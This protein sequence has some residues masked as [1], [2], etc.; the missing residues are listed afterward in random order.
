MSATKFL[1]V[2]TQRQCCKAFTGLSI[3][4]IML[5]WGLVLLENVAETD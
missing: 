3:R 4:A 1:C 2:N 5:R